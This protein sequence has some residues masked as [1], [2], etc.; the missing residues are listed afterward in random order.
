MAGV[1]LVNDVDD[2]RRAR[3]SANRLGRRALLTSHWVSSGVKE[4]TEHLV[5]VLDTWLKVPQLAGENAYFATVKQGV[6]SVMES[7]TEVLV[8]IAREFAGEYQSGAFR[9]TI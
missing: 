8:K 5:L 2:V 4:A 3:L 9:F 6:E 7:T 1:Y